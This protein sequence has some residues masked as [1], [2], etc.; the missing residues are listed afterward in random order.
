[1]STSGDHL[2][3]SQPVLLNVARGKEAALRC[4]SPG[5]T[6]HVTCSATGHHAR[7]DEHHRTSMPCATTGTRVMAC[8]QSRVSLSATS[9]GNPCEPALHIPGAAGT[10][11]STSQNT[12]AKW[13]GLESQCQ[14]CFVLFCFVLGEVHKSKPSSLRAPST[15]LLHMIHY[16]GGQG[17]LRD[18]GSSS[19]TIE[20]SGEDY[21]L[22]TKHEMY[23]Y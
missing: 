12:T 17:V 19:C 6:T 11:R 14:F 2:D 8:H 7:E 1:M 3:L 20:H 18:E 23:F 13:A 10:C 22:Q 16:P 9:Q 4:P 15:I 21:N 5:L